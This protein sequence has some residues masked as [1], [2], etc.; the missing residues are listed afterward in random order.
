MEK[1]GQ[2]L[3]L[4]LKFLHLI[5][6]LGPQ[7]RF[8]QYL[9]SSCVLRGHPVAANQENI[10]RHSWVKKE[11]RDKVYIKTA[12]FG[13]GDISPQPRAFDKSIQTFHRESCDKDYLG[14]EI[15]ESNSSFASVFVRWSGSDNWTEKLDELFWS[16]K[17]LDMETF[18]IKGS[19]E[20]NSWVRIET[21]CW[22]LEQSVLCEAVTG[23]SWSVVSLE[24]EKD[25]TKMKRHVQLAE[26]YVNQLQLFAK[27]TEGRNTNAQ[28]HIE[29][30]FSYE[31][32]VSLA[33]NEF[34]PARV[35]AAACD[36][37]I[38]IVANSCLQ[39]A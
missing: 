5:R 11:W 23:R 35:R 25:P 2:E 33:Y 31:H 12:A 21:L 17:S 38:F 28:S 37:G 20:H 36:L 13:Q 39:F 24:I 4:L 14:K 27:V 1:Y 19:E 7:S 34:L 3:S 22:V 10:I 30:E 32:C 6:D 16:P 26:Y 18:E 9:Q 8:L 15:Y 29:T